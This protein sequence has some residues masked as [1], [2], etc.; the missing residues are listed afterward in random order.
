[1]CGRTAAQVC[2]SPPLSLCTPAQEACPLVW[3]RAADHA[4]DPT[5]P[6]RHKA[7]LQEQLI[8]RT[9]RSPRD[10]FLT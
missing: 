7:S 9:P 1:M 3:V 4:G 8:Q 6:S 2:P 5:Q 10:Q